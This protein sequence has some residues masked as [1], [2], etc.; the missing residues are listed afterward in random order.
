M[1]T[2]LISEVL[3]F[4]TRRPFYLEKD[5]EEGIFGD[6]HY[7][8][9]CMQSQLLAV[10]VHLRSTQFSDWDLFSSRSLYSILSGLKRHLSDVNE[11]GALN[12][13]DMSDRE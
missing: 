3:Y 7:R 4:G 11:S 8:Y 5:F 1:E 12:S 2:E 10:E 9:V 13:M 6:G